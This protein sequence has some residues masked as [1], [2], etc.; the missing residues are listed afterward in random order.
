METILL[1]YAVYNIPDRYSNLLIIY[2]N[3]Y[4]RFTD[5]YLGTRRITLITDL[6]HK[7]KIIP[8][9]LLK[10]KHSLLSSDHYTYMRIATFLKAH[11]LIPTRIPHETWSFWNNVHKTTKGISLFYNL[12]QQ[13]KNLLIPHLFRS[14]KKD[15]ATLFSVEQWKKAVKYNQCYTRSTTYWDGTKNTTQMVLYPLHY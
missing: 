10:Q 12:L 1:L 14:G 4:S 8:F 7:G 15:F 2:S 11:P 13:K 6:L 9:Q 5:F 3:P